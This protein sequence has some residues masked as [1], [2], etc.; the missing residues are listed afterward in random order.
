MTARYATYPYSRLRPRLQIFSCQVSSH[1]LQQHYG[2]NRYIAERLWDT[3]REF[4]SK[5]RERN[6]LEGK[7]KTKT[8]RSHSKTPDKQGL[9]NRLRASVRRR[10]APACIPYNIRYGHALVSKNGRINTQTSQII[11]V[12]MEWQK[13]TGRP[14]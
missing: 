3:T 5:W 1:N 11:I 2:S 7:S 6:K 14:N 10:Q 4:Y 12:V 13:L 8:D 9:Y